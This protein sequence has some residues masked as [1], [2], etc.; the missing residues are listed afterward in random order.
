MNSTGEWLIRNILL[1]QS[2]LPD[3]DIEFDGD[4]GTWVRIEHFPL[5]N[6]FQQQQTDLLL[7]LPG[8]HQ[9]LATPPRSFYI[10]KNLK[11]SATGFT[12]AHIF[13]QGSVHGW[14]DLAN[15]GYANFC[16]ILHQWNPTQDIV[17]GDNLLT[18]VNTIF[19]HLSEL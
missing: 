2:A 15:Q 10:D 6:N 12:P 11:S 13:E 4:D 9:P 8:I 7:I 5:P 16:L 18:V 19:E 17:T 14:A 1:L 3:C